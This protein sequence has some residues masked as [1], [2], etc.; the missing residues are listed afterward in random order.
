[1]KITLS[2]PVP[3]AEF[4]KHIADMHISAAFEN[5]VLPVTDHGRPPRAALAPIHLINRWVAIEELLNQAALA[6]LSEEA[7]K[8]IFV[9]VIQMFRIGQTD[10]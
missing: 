4:R 7:Q 2:D 9:Q 6:V 8:L 10:T 1:M 5:K 3:L